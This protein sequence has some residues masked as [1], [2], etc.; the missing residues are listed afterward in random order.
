MSK[1][2][3]IPT[4]ERKVIIITLTPSSEL[5]SVS[6]QLPNRP[7]VL[8]PLDN[9]DDNVQDLNST[10]IDIVLDKKIIRN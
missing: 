10:N 4:T 8:S 2:I 6:E 5:P 1:S 7:G 9:N 3:V